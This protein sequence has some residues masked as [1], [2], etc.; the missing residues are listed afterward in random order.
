LANFIQCIY[1]GYRKDTPYHTDIH[2]ADVAQTCHSFII[3]GKLK[4]L[5]SL[6][7]HE[8]FAF[9]LSA[10]IHDYKHMGLNNAFHENKRTV[11]AIRYNDVSILENYHVA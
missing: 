8:I 3:N 1:A 4:S 2:A 11:L 9:L 7:N 5:F 6:T 10:I